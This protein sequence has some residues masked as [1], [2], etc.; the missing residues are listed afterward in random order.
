MPAAKSTTKASD[1]KQAQK[2]EVISPPI[3]RRKKGLWT[4]LH[5]GGFRE[6][7]EQ[8]GEQIYVEVGT[9]IEMLPAAAQPLVDIG[10]LRPVE[11]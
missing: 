9:V 5:D 4:W 3:A 11:G 1:Q 8:T 2:Y 6:N 7:G 10:R